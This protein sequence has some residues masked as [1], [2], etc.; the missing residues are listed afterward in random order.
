M[1]KPKTKPAPTKT[2]TEEIAKLRTMKVPQLVERYE[3]VYGKPP[4]VKHRDWLWRR[5]A[6]KI[7]EQK[8]GGLSEVAK[9][10]LDE[11]IAELDLPLTGDRTVRAKVNGTA[12][13]GEPVV[14]TT[15]TRAWKGRKIHATRTEE[16]WEHDGV[17]YR[18]LSAVVRAITGSHASGPAW[19]GL[20]KR[21]R[22]RD[23]R[24]K[25]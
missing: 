19:F 16:G 3:A 20:T 1:S 12:R 7:Q 4:R 6:W 22:S 18:S 5:I 25:K 24:A 17:V 8:F 10:R 15:L 23:R 9:R 2:I 13:C 14:G 11:L 21:K